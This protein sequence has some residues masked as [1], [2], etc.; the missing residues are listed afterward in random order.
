MSYIVNPPL[1]LVLAVPFRLERREVQTANIV[2]RTETDALPSPPSVPDLTFWNAC[3]RERPIMASTA[4]KLRTEG[5]QGKTEVLPAA[6]TSNWRRLN[7]RPAVVLMIL[8]SVFSLI[9]SCLPLRTAVQIGA[10]EGFELAK[11]TLCLNGYKLYSEVWNDQPPLHTFLITQVVKH[12][13]PSILGPR[14]VTSTFTVL[15]LSSVF[16]IGLRVSGLLVAALTSSLLIA[17]PGFLELSSSCMV[18]VPALAGA[19][20]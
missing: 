1:R 6:G 3:Q 12:L 15:L 5:R 19:K 2:W 17:S 8:L 11:A 4:F 20:H 16:F 7:R 13:S 9:Q 18:E 10:D 14:L